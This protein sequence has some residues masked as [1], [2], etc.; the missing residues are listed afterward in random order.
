ML[1]ELQAWERERAQDAPQLIVISTGSAEANRALE[2]RSTI[3]LDQDSTA[4]RAFGVSGT[5][6]A[7]LVDAGGKVSSLV[8]VGAPGVM[9]LLAPSRPALTS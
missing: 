5:P 7:V 4:M 8:A 6:S 1:A 2:L 3:V 9:S